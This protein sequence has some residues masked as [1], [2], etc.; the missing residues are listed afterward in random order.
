MAR[1]QCTVCGYI[2]DEE[3]KGKPFSE[4]EACPLCKAP[5]A[6]F[7]K[8]ED[9]PETSGESVIP[10]GELAYDEAT[11]R[12]DKTARHMDEIHDMAVTGKRLDAA[13]GTQLPMPDWED[14]LLL[15]AQLDPAPLDDGAQVSTKT[16]IG[17]NARQ[18]M[19]LESPVFIS[20]M[21]FGALSKEI[22]VALAKGSAAVKTAMCSGE[23]GILPEERAASY[24]YIFEYVPNKYSVTEESLKNAD[25]IEIKIGQGTKPGMGGHLPGEKVTPEI[26]ELRGKKEGEDIQSPSR[27]PEIKTKEDLK[28]M[29]DMLRERSG[30]RPVGVKIAAGHIEQDLA[31]CIYSGADFITIDGRGGATGSS[32]L[33]LRDNTSVPTLFALARARKFLDLAGSEAALIIT[34][35]LR[36]SS[37]FAK[38]LAMGADAVAIASA[39]L[40]AAACQQYRICGSGK[41]PVGIATQDPELRKRLDV[42]K[43]AARVANFLRVSNDELK[44]FAR[45][46][47]KTSVHELSYDDIVTTDENVAAYTGIRHA[48]ERE[49]VTPG[50]AF[51][52]AST[53]SAAGTDKQSADES[54]GASS[55]GSAH[56]AS[57]S[58]SSIR[59]A[60][61]AAAT[62]VLTAGAVSARVGAERIRNM[63]QNLKEAS[64]TFAEKQKTKKE[65][66]KMVKVRCKVC[67]EV[68]EAESLETA[69]CPKCG[70]KG[71]SLE[72]VEEGKS[73]PYAGTQTEKNL[74]AAFAGES[75]ARNKYTY[76]ASKAKKEGFEQ[77]AALFLKTA[78]NEK[79]H[80]KIW[81]KE[82]NGIG[83]TTE[84]LAAAAEG[85][86]YEWTDMYEGFAKTA[87]EEGFPELAAKFRMVGEIEKHHE[88]RYRALLKNVEMQEVFK[89]SEVKVWECRNCGHIVVGTQAPEVCPVCAHPQSFFEVHEE[90]Y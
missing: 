21:S 23:G 27:F 53:G 70:M 28:S 12:S 18:P 34:G 55:S 64:E 54:S 61:A 73:N 57:S 30:G 38:A 31:W 44:M 42:E 2:Y 26:A 69:V 79:E 25:A 20:H 11:Y 83:T 22:K 4:L 47:G 48:G 8:L 71:D 86:N 33:M 84:N 24:K 32:P 59:E 7:V 10:A 85:E 78:D 37:D 46:T 58:A 52:D 51:R 41:C 50:A 17:K 40:I 63:A 66:T 68:F 19:E 60:L 35:G 49:D 14:V 15:G 87:E 29:V 89:K 90:N 16:V 76:F 6:K 56:G 75:Q 13:M 80:A 62:S 82:L 77:I 5:Q 9:E 81:F 43:A 3:Q 65:E 74:Q 45:V 1:Y 88:E 67:G 36:V 39:A 72:L